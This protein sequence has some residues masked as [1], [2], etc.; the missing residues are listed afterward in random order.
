VSGRTSEPLLLPRLL[1]ARINLVD[2]LAIICVLGLAVAIAET[3]QH[4]LAPLGV[5]GTDPIHLDPTYLPFYAFR[6]TLRMFAGLA[7]SGLFTL[8]YGTLAAKSRVAG[9]LLIPALDIL[10][11]V[12]ILGFLTFT[13]VFFMGLF[14][15]R[16]LG[17]E[18]AAIF[19]I[20]TS[21]VWNMTFAFHR[22][23][24]SLPPELD[25]AARG[26]RLT[27][28][29][30]F[31]RVE[32]PFAVPTLVWNTIVSVSGGWFMVVYSETITVGSTHVVLPGIGSYVGA[33]IAQRNLWAVLY[34]IIAMMVV[35]VLYDQI[36]F[37]PLLAW[38]E[39][40]RLGS[41]STESQRDPWMLTLIR[42]STL[43]RRASEGT[44]HMMGRLGTLPL[45]ARPGMD[46]GVLGDGSQGL[47]HVGM[48][49]L[50]I[51]TVL[52]L[53][54]LWAYGQDHFTLADIAAAVVLG[55]FTLLR[56]SIMVAL[57]SLIWV[58]IGVW[59][60]LRPRWGA[61]A[62]L[63]AQFMSAFPANLFFPIFVFVIV[64][65]NLNSDVWLSP[66]M[67]LGAQWYILFNVAAGAASIPSDVLEVARVFR[68][69]GLRWW[70]RVALPAVAPAYLTGALAASGGAWNAAIAAEMASWGD[71]RLH[72]HGLGAYIAQATLQGSVAHVALGMLV[73]A[74][75]VVA[76]NRL[77]WH[78]AR[79]FAERRY[80][81]LG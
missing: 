25:E 81:L 43:A 78:P 2:L 33:A 38:S 20:F 56:V 32:V 52:A 27:G 54:R 17:A 3:V 4:T 46:R 18:L 37:R 70:M 31:W 75:Y 6:T 48:T 66:L 28:W 57:A 71:T 76:F 5:P 62:R 22:A 16:I 65:F 8:L 34:A 35:I 77:V 29:Q 79:I 58:P 67:I 68:V 60:G 10:Q 24:R 19:A 7:L 9:T 41:A 14:P 69:R 1:G 44:R 53:W 72:A 45:G 39:R 63:A 23:L 36:L 74:F 40:F 15:G 30:K 51:L 12:P 50:A 47:G 80:T 11:S 73:M 13:V 59:V 49:V 26:F 42:R 64:R 21:Q 61:P 55:A